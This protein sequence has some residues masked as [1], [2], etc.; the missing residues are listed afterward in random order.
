MAHILAQYLNKS[1]KKYILIYKYIKIILL[2]M[3]FII[4]NIKYIDMMITIFFIDWFSF[5]GISYEK[6]FIDF[7]VVPRYGPS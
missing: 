5:N 2:G 7:I 3:I 6:K 1:V 4:F